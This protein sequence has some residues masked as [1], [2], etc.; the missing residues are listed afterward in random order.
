MNTLAPQISVVI[1]RIIHTANTCYEN[2]GWPVV[3]RRSACLWDHWD[4]RQENSP[5][6]YI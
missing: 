2:V 6:L 5:P 1:A 3:G 4:R